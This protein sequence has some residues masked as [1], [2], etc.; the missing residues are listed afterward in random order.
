VNTFYVFI[1]T[2]FKSG[3]LAEVPLIFSPFRN[4]YRNETATQSGGNAGKM[5]IHAKIALKR[6]SS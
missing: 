3:S 1:P 6:V 2:C 4:K 5:I